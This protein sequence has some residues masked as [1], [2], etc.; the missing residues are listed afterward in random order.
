VLYSTTIDDIAASPPQTKRNIGCNIEM[1]ACFQIS[2]INNTWRR[3]LA[4][5]SLA[6]ISSTEGGVLGSPSKRL[7]NLGGRTFGEFNIAL[8][9]L[10]VK[11]KATPPPATLSGSVISSIYVNYGFHDSRFEVLF[12]FFCDLKI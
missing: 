8:S 11:L 12:F 3:R 7:P 6:S 10:T 4:S 5:R 1:V 2:K 9:S